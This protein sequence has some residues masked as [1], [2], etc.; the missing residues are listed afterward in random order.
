MPPDATSAPEGQAPA[1][2]APQAGDPTGQAPE[3][4]S[5]DGTPT[6]DAAALQR[7]LAAARR[8][9]ASYRTKL[10]GYEDATKS[11]AEKAAERIAELE[12]QN[13]ELAA[14]RREDSLRISASTE[15]RK[16]GFRNPDLAFRLIASA[17]EYDDH[18]TPK[19]VDRLL[20]DVA[21]SDP[22]LVNGPADFG[23]G[24]RGTAPAAGNNMNELI[25]RAAGR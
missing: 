11:E 19:N 17:V 5:G 12:R 15:A 8:E 7:E 14:A 1:D 20:A 21:K 22:Y 25:R 10:K 24:P 4:S 23:G 2:E 16:L 6:L 9:A 13:S 18:G 3:P